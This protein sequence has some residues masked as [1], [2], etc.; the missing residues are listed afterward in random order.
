MDSIG[1][2]L[3]EERER[4]GYSQ[5]AF[6]ALAEVTKQSQI[7]YEKGERSPD[8]SYLAAI[9]RVG[10]DVQYIVGAIRS[11]MALAPDEQELVSRYRSASLEVKAAAIG[12]LAAA[13][14]TRQEQVFHGSVGQAVK[15]E[16]NLDQQGISFFGKGKKRK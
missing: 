1:E 9:M 14:T 13:S 7:K 5:T 8:A 4:L 10:A 11:S 16:G 6:G 15:V 2:R 12:A 3:R